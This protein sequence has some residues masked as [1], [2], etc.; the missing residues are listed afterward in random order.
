MVW[1]LTVEVWGGLGRRG[2]GGKLDNYNSINN[3]KWFKERINC[4]ASLKYKI[5]DHAL[6]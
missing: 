3:N 5:L 6:P 2:Q 4:D 1:A